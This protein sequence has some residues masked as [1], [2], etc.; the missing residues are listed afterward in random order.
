[1]VAGHGRRLALLSMAAKGSDP[2]VP[3]VW[4]PLTDEQASAYAVADNRLTDLSEWNV[5]GLRAVM[6]ELDNGAFDMEATGFTAEALGDLFGAPGPTSGILPGK[7]PE[8][9]PPLPPPAEVVS[10][11]GD[12]IILGDHRLLCGDS[13]DPLAWAR[14]M[15]G[16]KADLV[17]TDP[18]YGVSYESSAAG[19]KADGRAS[20]QN[21]AL[22]GE[23][24]QS[25]L[26][27]TFSCLASVSQKKAAFYVFY[28]SRFHREFETGL[29]R[30]RLDVRAQIIWVK[31]AASFGFAQYKWKHE[32]VLMAAAEGEVPLVYLPAHETAFY[33][34]KQGNSPF[35]EGDRCQTTVWS[36]SRETGYVHPC[37]APDSLVMTSS[38]FRPIGE[39]ETGTLILG[40]D[41]ALHPVTATTRHPYL[42]PIVE[43]GVEGT[44]LTVRASDNHPFLVARPSYSGTS[45]SG[46][47]TGFVAAEDVNVG[48][49]ILSPRPT[50]GTLEPMSPEE[51]WVVGLF[52]AEGSFQKAGHGANRYPVF[53]LH[54]NEMDFVGRLVDLYGDRVK[55]YADRTNGLAVMVFDAA[56]GERLFGLCGIHAHSKVL[57]DEVWDWIPSLVRALVDGY[58]AGDGCRVRLER[59]AKTV[60]VAI[61][62]QIAH[63]ADGVGFRSNLYRYAPVGGSI[64]GRVFKSTRP[65]YHLLLHD[66]TEQVGM[67]RRMTAALPYIWEGRPYFL[68]RVKSVSFSAYSGDVVNLTVDG[69]HTFQTA[70]GMSHNTQKPVELLKKPM[71]NSSRPGMLVVDAFGGSGSTL[72]TCEMLGRRSC[73]M[74]LSEAFCDVIITRWQNATGK[75]AVR[76]RTE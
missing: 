42:K 18:P 39:I 70:V 57:A 69:C 45:I 7:D 66:E 6:A 25:F 63:L 20:I 29:N 53:H 15:E 9:A 68:R 1:M 35:W 8:D 59:R 41:G 28:P 56:L 50:L 23:A 13:T 12:L 43:I 16:A 67:N 51:A 76:H 22:T 72:I 31:N 48:D 17:L 46:F 27:R 65:F 60:S 5:P 37:L 61:A 3:V 75:I 21:D 10:R 11:L 74:E 34:F 32:P 71:L 36:V 33:A 62:S 44:N 47:E 73:T 4:A 64:A 55:V 49:F 54:K 58:L 38:G 24:F 19:L 2:E 40:H 30:A 26:D 52:L 14:L